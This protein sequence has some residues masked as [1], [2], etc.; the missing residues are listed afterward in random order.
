MATLI[1]GGVRAQ[2][3]VF[4][5]ANKQIGLID[6]CSNNNFSCIVRMKAANGSY[7]RVA[8]SSGG[9]FSLYDNATKGI[10]YT[11]TGCAGE[12]YIAPANTLIPEVPLVNGAVSNGNFSATIYSPTTRV[13]PISYKSFK[14]IGGSCVKQNGNIGG[15]QF[16]SQGI[17]YKLPF[18]VK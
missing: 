11:G 10:Y 9:M 18:N 5:S 13:K 15:T 16:V 17:T 8:V 3:A 1:S 2:T 6:S 7:V 12:S 14:S 4:D